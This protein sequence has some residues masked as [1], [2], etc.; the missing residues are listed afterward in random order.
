[1]VGAVLTRMIVWSVRRPRSGGTETRSDPLGQP[2]LL[3]REKGRVSSGRD[4]RTDAGVARGEAV[5]HPRPYC[6]SEN[7]CIVPAF[8]CGYNSVEGG[9]VL[10][11]FAFFAIVNHGVPMNIVFA[12]WLLTGLLYL[13][14]GR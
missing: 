14:V 9:G 1:M 5:V 4:R 13:G 2:G 12:P 6:Y 10:R 8:D 11:V 7:G 3:C